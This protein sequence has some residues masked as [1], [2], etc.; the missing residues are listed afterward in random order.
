MSGEF[1]FKITGGEELAKALESKPPVVARAI[2]KDSLKRAVVP[3]REEMIDRVRKGWHVFSSGLEAIGLKRQRGATR[4]KGR[5]REY[6][7]IAQNIRVS[8]TVDD[9][10]YS[11]T[12]AVSP[13]K[14]AFW[15]KFL[16]FGTRHEKSIPFIRPAFETRKQDVLEEFI[17]DVRDRLRTEMGL[18]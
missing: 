18:K 11:G 8:T 2:I 13:S 14:R 9:S 15:A 17:E 1:S 5:Q 3:W 6:G 12:A 10:G 16:E 7:V 4:F